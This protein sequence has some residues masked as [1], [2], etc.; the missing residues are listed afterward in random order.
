MK[1][2]HPKTGLLAAAMLVAAA[3]IWPA[4]SHAAKFKRA[5]VT[6]LVNDVK[7][8]TGTQTSHPAS[9]G[10]VVSGSI[11]VRTGQKSRTELQFKDES[12]VRLGSNSV[13][14]F[15]EGKRQVD[16]KEGTLLM[17]VPKSLGRTSVKTAAISA[18]ITGTTILIEFV[19]PVYNSKGKLI[20]PGRIKI[21]VVEGVFEFSLDIAPRDKMELF[22]GEMVAFSAD[23]KELPRK[24]KIDLENLIKTSLLMGGG[25]GPLPNSLLMDAE[26]VA[27]NMEKRRGGLLEQNDR[28]RP[29][30]RI[31]PRIFGGNSIGLARDVIKGRPPI[32]NIPAPVII[33]GP[34]PGNNNPP[35]GG[36]PPQPPPIPLPPR[37]PRPQPGT[38][39]N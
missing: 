25:M 21:I 12:V 34:G 32:I 3:L 7:L 11:A 29:L 37:P 18:A 24:F 39:P 30:G 5:E 33:A 38:P 6:K 17:Q 36:T 15:L 2:K 22:A 4:A 19:P 27:Q 13:F 26:T 35:T 16:L 28:R 1:R 23:A 9:R 14:S 20:K 10:S 8:L 31:L